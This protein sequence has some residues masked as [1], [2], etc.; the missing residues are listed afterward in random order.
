MKATG[1]LASKVLSSKNHA[2]SI[3]YFYNPKDNL[4]KRF[5]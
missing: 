4:F 1:D 2:S 5:L 3:T